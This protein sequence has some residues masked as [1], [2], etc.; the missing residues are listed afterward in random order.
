MKLFQTYRDRAKAAGKGLW[1]KR[2]GK[3]NVPST[4][5]VYITKAYRIFNGF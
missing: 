4:A 2:L 3:A 1:A 5:L